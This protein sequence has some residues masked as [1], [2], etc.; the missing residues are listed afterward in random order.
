MKIFIADDSA[1]LRERLIDMLSELD[2][3][4]IVGQARDSLS[5][6]RSILKLKPDVVI[7]DIRM[8]GGN[9]ISV[10]QSI[11][12]NK[13]ASI[14]IMFT[15]YPYPQ[16]RKRCMDAG[17]DFFFDKSGEFEKITKVLKKLIKNSRVPKKENKTGIQSANSEEALFKGLLCHR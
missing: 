13:V 9:G 17:A 5:A 3:I 11:K 1:L 15:N 2:G 12:K 14:V 7:L 10:L 16:Y 8:P 6:V 4:E